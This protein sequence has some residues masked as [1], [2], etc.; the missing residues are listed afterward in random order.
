MVAKGSFKNES[1][2]PI[3]AELDAKM[4]NKCYRGKKIVIPLLDISRLLD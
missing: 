1:N 3:G 2:F 4:N